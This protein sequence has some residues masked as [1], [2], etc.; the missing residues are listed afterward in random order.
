MHRSF[1]MLSLQ[2]RVAEKLE[3]K[4]A[5]ISIAHEMNITAC[6]AIG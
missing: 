6:N 1:A 3:P 4:S 2:T 5:A